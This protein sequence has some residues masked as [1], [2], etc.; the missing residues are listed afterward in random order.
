MAYLLVTVISP[1]RGEPGQSFANLSVAWNWVV[2]AR[3]QWT[4]RSEP[5]RPIIPL[6]GYIEREP[7]T[8]PPLSG[9]QLPFKGGISSYCGVFKGD[10]LL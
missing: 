3:Q 2:C 1:E 9:K 8:A 5:K 6:D 10:F 4:V 7:V